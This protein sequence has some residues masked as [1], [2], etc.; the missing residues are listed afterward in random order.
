MVVLRW[1]RAP[2]P[3]PLAD[4]DRPECLLWKIHHIGLKA[5]PGMTPARLAALIE[6]VAEI[7]GWPLYGRVSTFCSQPSLTEIDQ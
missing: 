5:W 3:I 7:K 2:Y 6:I 1:G 4:L